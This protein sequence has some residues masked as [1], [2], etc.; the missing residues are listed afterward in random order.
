MTKSI[1]F[2]LIMVRFVLGNAQESNVSI[3]T[4]L[5][6]T[7]ISELKKQIEEK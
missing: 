1:V 4:K 2:I 3:Q 6:Q 5:D 7:E